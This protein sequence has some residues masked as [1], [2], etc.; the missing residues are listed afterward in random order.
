[1]LSERKRLADV[2]STIEISGREQFYPEPGEGS[3]VIPDAKWD[4]RGPAVTFSMPGGELPKW[5]S[6]RM[7]KASQSATAIWRT[8]EAVR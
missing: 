4:L 1:M 5:S 2:L 6:F 8:P 3:D 7:I